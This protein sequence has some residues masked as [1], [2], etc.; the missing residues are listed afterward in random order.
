M[1]TQC[2]IFNIDLFTIKKEEIDFMSGYKITFTEDN[3]F[4]ELVSWYNVYF[5]KVNKKVELFSGPL[6][7]PTHWKQTVFYIEDDFQMK[8]GD[9][10]WGNI[11]V[12]K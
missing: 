11:V 8:I 4:N 9:N 3:C 7:E 1:T 2:K 5:N 10:L 6:D 12:I